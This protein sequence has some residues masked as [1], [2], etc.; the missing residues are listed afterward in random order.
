[1][2]VKKPRLLASGRLWRYLL[3]TSRTL[4]DVG[5]IALCIS[6][7]VP[8][9]LRLPLRRLCAL[10]LNVCRGRGLHRGYRRIVVGRW[11][12]V[13]RR[14]IKPGPKN[15]TTHEDTK[16]DLVYGPDTDKTHLV[17]RPKPAKTDLVHRPKP[18]KTDLVYR[19]ETANVD[20]VCRLETANVDVVCR[21]GTA[22]VHL[23]ATSQ[24]R[25]TRHGPH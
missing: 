18:A 10:L 22:N 25:S 6:A 21:L 12:V 3:P 15:R 9:T 2:W 11:I 19:A 24:R 20:V 5:V 8:V 13:G 16:A 17:D 23:P 14:V 4:L 1:M 7:V